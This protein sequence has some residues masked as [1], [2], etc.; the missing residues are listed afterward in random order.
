MIIYCLTMIF[1][2]IKMQHLLLRKN[3]DLYEFTEE[4]A[5]DETKTYSMRDNDFMF[6]ISAF[7]WTKGVRTDPRYVQFVT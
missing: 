4:A 1:G 2:I 5:F 3:P 6:A 7:S